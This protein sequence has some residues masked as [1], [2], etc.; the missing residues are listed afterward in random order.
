MHLPTHWHRLHAA[1]LD[2]HGGIALARTRCH[3]FCSV[4]RVVCCTSLRVVCLAGSAS[5]MASRLLV[6]CVHSCA[7]RQGTAS[8]LLGR[9]WLPAWQQPGSQAELGECHLH[10]LSSWR[11]PVGSHITNAASPSESTL[12]QSLLLFG[13]NWQHQVNSEPYAGLQSFAPQLVNLRHFRSSTGKTPAGECTVAHVTRPSVNDYFFAAYCAKRDFYETLG[14][15]KTASD[16]DIKKAYYKLAKQYHP[17][18]NKVGIL[19][20]LCRHI[21]YMS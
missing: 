18:S 6:G 3:I 14:V 8:N 13:A 21:N 9:C 19:T 11:L 12:L 2:R 17:D 4:D 1:L 16:A 7:R 20:H 10:T 5:R 15:S